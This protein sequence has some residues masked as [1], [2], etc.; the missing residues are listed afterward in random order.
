MPEND[1]TLPSPLDHVRIVCVDSLY[2]GNLGSICRAMA[3]MGLKRLDLVRPSPSL[4]IAELRKM[5]VRA[6]GLYD[7][8]R[9]FATLAEAVSDC[10]AVACTSARDGFYRDHARTPRDW[11]PDLL[12]KTAEGPV[13]LVFGSENKGLDNDDLKLATHMLRIPTDPG[14][15][16]LNLAQAVL[17]CAYELFV[18]AGAFEP[19][20]ERSGLADHGSRERMFGWWEKAMLASGF[21]QADKL[22][23]M[24]MGMR[25]ILSRGDLTENDVK[26]LTGL[27]RQCTWAALQ[28]PPKAD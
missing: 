27:G 16:S 25:R 4:D 23:H 12:A 6:D 13:A 19:P 5:A 21:C 11:A 20:M 22:D 26:I 2:G 8:R 3:N 28:A 1:P 17:L 14:Y 7:R 10:V 15:S 24:M 9:E 18:A